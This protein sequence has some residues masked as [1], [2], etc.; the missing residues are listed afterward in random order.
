MP[1]VFKLNIITQDFYI[2]SFTPLNTPFV[3]ETLS[4]LNHSLVIAKGME[5]ILNK[6][7]PTK[8]S[9]SLCDTDAQC[10]CVR[11]ESTVKVQPVHKPN[12]K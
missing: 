1:K 9:W 3:I 7:F 6:L 11:Q 12:H 4:K 10:G 2:I 8:E 5:F